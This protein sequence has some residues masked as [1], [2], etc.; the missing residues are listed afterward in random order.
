VA[1]RRE[2]VPDWK[3]GPF[4]SLD[5]D[6][7][8]RGSGVEPLVATGVAGSADLLAIEWLPDNQARLILDHWSHAGFYSP[9]FTWTPERM[10]HLR[11]VLPSLAALDGRVPSSG[12]GKLEVEVDGVRIWDE[13]VPY[14]GAP[15][16]TFAFGR[17]SVGS[18][19]ALSALGPRLGDIR[20][21]FGK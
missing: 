2:P 12:S 13:Q 10:H 11:L 14:Y 8:G 3:P 9:R 6:L 1:L 18:S 15:S 7:V 5:V 21:G 4:T 20:Q 17:N 16:A 19:V